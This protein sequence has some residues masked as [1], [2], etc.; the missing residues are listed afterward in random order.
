MKIQNKPLFW[1]GFTLQ[2]I[3]LTILGIFGL[4]MLNWDWITIKLAKV[5]LVILGMILYEG[6]VFVMMYFGLKRDPSDVEKDK[7]EDLE[8]EIKKQERKIKRLKK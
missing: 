4:A 8:A 1:T 7:I 5:V 2:I 3:P 6:L